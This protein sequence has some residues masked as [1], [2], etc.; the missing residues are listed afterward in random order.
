MIAITTWPRKKPT[1]RVVPP[2][3]P[4]KRVCA[5]CGR[6]LDQSEC[7]EDVQVTHGICQVCRRRFFAS[8]KAKEGYSRSTRDDVGGEPGGPEGTCKT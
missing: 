5:W 4:M 3:V 1:P 8:A 7:R 6:E 2:V